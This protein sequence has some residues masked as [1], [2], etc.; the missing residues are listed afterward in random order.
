MMSD[1]QGVIFVALS[2]RGVIGAPTGGEVKPK[3]LFA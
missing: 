2:W 3:V 1:L